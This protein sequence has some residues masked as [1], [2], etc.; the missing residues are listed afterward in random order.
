[1]H[2]LLITE[3]KFRKHALWFFLFRSIWA[4]SDML[5]VRLFFFLL[6]QCTD[7]KKQPFLTWTQDT[8]CLCTSDVTKLCNRWSQGPLSL[9]CCQG[10][11]IGFVLSVRSCS[12][13]VVNERITYLLLISLVKAR[14]QHNLY[15]NHF[16]T[17]C[18]KCL[19]TDRVPV[20]HS[21][22]VRTRC[23]TCL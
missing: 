2:V 9:C 12:D 1:M 6:L 22:R 14:A 8:T 15:L 23:T 7:E 4:D 10:V 21:F 18:S 13:C 17:F 20:S 16:F 19:N 3:E 5:N 11:S